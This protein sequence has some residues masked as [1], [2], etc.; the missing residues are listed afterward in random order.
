MATKAQAVRKARRS[1]DGHGKTWQHT[2]GK[3][4]TCICGSSLPMIPS[5]ESE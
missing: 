5:A 2:F 4:A 3:F 1:R